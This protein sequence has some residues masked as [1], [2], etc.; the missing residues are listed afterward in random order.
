MSIVWWSGKSNAF[1]RLERSQK[2][3]VRAVVFANRRT[4]TAPIFKQLNVLTIEKINKLQT[5]SFVFKAI[6]RPSQFTNFF[7]PNYLVHSHNTRQQFKL[8]SV[9]HRINCRANSIRIFG[10]KLWNSI[11][12]ELR[13]SPT[14]KSFQKQYK[15]LLIITDN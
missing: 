15:Q 12:N 2:R 1:R 5:A 8:H 3:A 9:P 11:S 10:S 13:T 7:T 4:H 14:V 6:N